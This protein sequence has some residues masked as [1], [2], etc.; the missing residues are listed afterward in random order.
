MKIYSWLLGSLQRLR[1]AQ[2][3]AF[4]SSL[5]VLGLV[6]LCLLYLLLL[7]L[8]V[9][10]SGLQVLLT[11]WCLAKENEGPKKE[12]PRNDEPTEPVK[13]PLEARRWAPTEPPKELPPLPEEEDEEDG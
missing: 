2:C 3:W 9:F 13:G 10:L 12:E 11:V 4:F 5:S 7:T 6:Q 8:L 1:Q